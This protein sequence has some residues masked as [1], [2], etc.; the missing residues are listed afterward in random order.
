MPAYEASINMRR[1]LVK[2]GSA[3]FQ[4]SSRLA[5]LLSQEYPSTEKALKELVDN[6]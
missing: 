1:E 6:A 3:R 2:K 4:V 5:S